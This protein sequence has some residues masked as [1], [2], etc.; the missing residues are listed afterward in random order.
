[1]LVEISLLCA[2]CES[3]YN[4]CSVYICL[5]S[6]CRPNQALEYIL[7]PD[8]DSKLSKL[9]GSESEEEPTRQLKQGH[10]IEYTYANTTKSSG[11]SENEESI[12]RLPDK[13]NERNHGFWWRLS[14]PVLAITYLKK[15]VYFLK[16]GLPWNTIKCFGMMNS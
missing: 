14:K 15:R 6:F 10:E 5:S 11:D 8:S 2:F 12:P 3:F 9:L 16:F 13:T 1:M 4:L 7:K